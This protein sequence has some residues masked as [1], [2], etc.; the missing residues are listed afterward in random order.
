MGGWGSSEV[1]ISS[2]TAARKMDD[3][4]LRTHRRDETP[5]ITSRE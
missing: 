5:N 2:I 3:E 1:C 4:G